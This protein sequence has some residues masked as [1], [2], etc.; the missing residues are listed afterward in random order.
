M[1]VTNTATRTLSKMA[2]PG[3]P[4]KN[5]RKGKH[6]E[7]AQRRI[8]VAELSSQGVSFQAISEQLGISKTKVSQDYHQYLAELDDPADRDARRLRLREIYEFDLN[9][10]WQ[11]LHEAGGLFSQSIADN[12]KEDML[13]YSQIVSKLEDRRDRLLKNLRELDGLDQPKKV[14]VTSNS[15]TVWTPLVEAEA[16]SIIQHAYNVSQ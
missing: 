6:L 10:N 1:V 9:R 12:R 11:Q 2:S 3:R 8:R 5:E 4:K 7:M 16:I 14:D 15:E 13:K